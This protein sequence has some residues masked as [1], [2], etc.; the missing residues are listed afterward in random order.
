MSAEA[1][2][3]AGKEMGV[4]I[5]VEKQGANG[6]EDMHKKADIKKADGVIF[7]CDISVKNIERY[8][9]KNFVKVK[10]AEPLKDAKA[11][12]ERV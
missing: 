4:R 3:K 2:E 7:A 9:G 10:V 8:N 11:L 6:I 1:L 12:I 5:L